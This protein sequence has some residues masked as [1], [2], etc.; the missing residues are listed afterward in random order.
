MSVVFERPSLWR[1]LQPIFSG[2]DLDPFLNAKNDTALRAKLGI[3][4][5]DFVV[6]KV[7]RMFEHKGHF[8]LIAAVSILA[9]LKWKRSGDWPCRRHIGWS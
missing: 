9:R 5:E 2:F 4:P 1:R 3:G 8:D 7:A 6:G